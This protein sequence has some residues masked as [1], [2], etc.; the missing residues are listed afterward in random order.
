MSSLFILGFQK[1][2]NHLLLEIRD[3]L[4]NLEK[5][6]QVEGNVQLPNIV[7]MNSLD[8][9]R[10]FDRTLTNV[11][12]R[13]LYVSKVTL[14]LKEMNWKLLKWFSIIISQYVLHYEQVQFFTPYERYPIEKIELGNKSCGEVQTGKHSYIYKYYFV[15][16]L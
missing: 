11:E 4:K 3:C 1:R 9:F 8:E 7:Q 12:T 5:G 13:S 6:R 15:Q 14:K 16:E 2:V 10:A